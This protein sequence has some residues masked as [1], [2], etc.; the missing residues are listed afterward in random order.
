MFVTHILNKQ[1]DGRGL[2]NLLHIQRIAGEL[3][4]IVEIDL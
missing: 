3:H 2:S 4:P 1:F